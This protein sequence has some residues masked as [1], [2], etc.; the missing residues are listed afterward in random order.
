MLSSAAM[1][2][3]I[4][5]LLTP[6]APTPGVVSGLDIAVQG[7]TPTERARAFLT[8]SPLLRD[9]PLRSVDARVR[10]SRAVVRFAQVHRLG[11]REVP[12]LDRGATVTLR[13]GRVV[14]LN[15]EAVALRE[16][17]AAKIDAD[18]ARRLAARAVLGAEGPTGG[19]R[20]VVLAVGDRGVAGF[21]V[22]VVRIPFVEHFVVRVDAHAGRVVGARN[23]IIR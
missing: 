3:M 11:G 6:P 17:A 22:D 20:E 4:V 5:L 8:G 19:V 18:T 1:M 16:V 7:A 13:E 23:R 21:E 9:I 15:N 12:V 14:A 2:W 10:G